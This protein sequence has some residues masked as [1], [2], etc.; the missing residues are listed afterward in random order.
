MAKS[1]PNRNPEVKQLLGQ[2][3]RLTGPRG[4]KFLMCRNGSLYW[5]APSPHANVLDQ[6]WHNFVPGRGRRCGYPAH[7]RLQRQLRLNRQAAKA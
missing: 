3:F 2:G 6:V 5:P 1:T 4:V 7:K